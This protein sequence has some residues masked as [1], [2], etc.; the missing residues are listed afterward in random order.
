MCS[1]D[2]DKRFKQK[3]PR[4]LEDLPREWCPLAVLRLKQI[5][6]IKEEITEEVEN[7]MPGCPFYISSQLSNYC[8][9]VYESNNLD[10]S[11]SDLEI[12]NLLGISID[13]VKK[14]EQSAI[15]KLKDNDSLVELKGHL[16]GESVISSV[17]NIED[18]LIY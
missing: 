11:M 4:K 15:N 3:C 6:N 2:L 1:S 16:N 5:K 9:F 12:A 14:A 13:A 17:L 7:K 18:E 10:H 8:F